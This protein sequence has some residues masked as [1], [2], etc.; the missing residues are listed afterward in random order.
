MCTAGTQMCEK[1]KYVAIA[2]LLEQLLI[3]LLEQWEHLVQR[4]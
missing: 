1:G 3:V 4:M 2:L